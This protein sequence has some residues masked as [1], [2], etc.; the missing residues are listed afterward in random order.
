MS[1]W[2][3]VNPTP[4]ADFPA[5]VESAPL[6]EL[7]SAEDSA[8]RAAQVEQ[9]TAAKAAAVAIFQSGAIGPT[10]AG[11]YGA[12]LGGHANPGHEPREHWSNDTV[13]I[14]IYRADPRTTP[15]APDADADASA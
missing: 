13:S 2:I 15:P 12:N 8:M 6:P 11:S 5:A 14:G 9:I 7:G 3:A 4:A 10:D 1:W